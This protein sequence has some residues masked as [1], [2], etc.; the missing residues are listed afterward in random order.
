MESSRKS[1]DLQQ[2]APGPLQ[3]GSGAL[4]EPA[5]VLQGETGVLKA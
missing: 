3:H 4:R 5:A 2:V 1:F